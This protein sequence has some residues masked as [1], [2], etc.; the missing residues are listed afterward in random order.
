[1]DR[2]ICEQER[3]DRQALN[4]RSSA[5][6]WF[7]RRGSE[8]GWPKSRVGGERILNRADKLRGS[9]AQDVVSASDSAATAYG[10]VTQAIIG[11]GPSGLVCAK[12]CRQRGQRVTVLE[13]A[14]SAGGTWRFDPVPADLEELNRKILFTLDPQNTLGC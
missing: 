3:E 1:M 6:G 8:G 13:K 10:R 9:T 12:E 2:G 14:T 7:S 5:R 4:A 11:A